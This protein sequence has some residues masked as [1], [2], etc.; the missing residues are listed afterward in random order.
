MD[1]NVI[2]FNEA[3]DIV[4]SRKYQFI[5]R[6]G[7]NTLQ[8]FCLNSDSSLLYL[9]PQDQILVNDGEQ[10]GLF[11]PQLDTQAN[12]QTNLVNIH[13]SS[14]G[15]LDFLLNF[16]DVDNKLTLFGNVKVTVE[17][18]GSYSTDKA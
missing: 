14:D 15:K 7:Q 18:F 4:D 10:I 13:V 9:L 17:S 8:K 16:E 6:S 3:A 1:S 2:T 11:K 5:G 12:T